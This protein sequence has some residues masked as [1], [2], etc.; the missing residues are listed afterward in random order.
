MKVE[1]EDEWSALSCLLSSAVACQ[2]AD[3]DSC[4]SRLDAAVAVLPEV[5]FLVPV[6]F[7]GL[8]AVFAASAAAL[9]FE[10]V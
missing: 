2:M 7:V 5:D 3:D 4:P 1:C 6:L 8:F 10:R 9:S